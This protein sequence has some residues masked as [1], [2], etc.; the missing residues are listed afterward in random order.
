MKKR[1]GVWEMKWEF[2][3]RLRTW[4]VSGAVGDGELEAWKDCLN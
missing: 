3:L 1:E 4:C 2:V